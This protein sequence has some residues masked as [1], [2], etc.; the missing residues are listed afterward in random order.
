[1]FVCKVASHLT[2]GE[3]IKNICRR[4]GGFGGTTACGGRSRGLVTASV[5]SG[6]ATPPAAGD[7]IGAW[8][9]PV[10]GHAPWPNRVDEK[11]PCHINGL[12]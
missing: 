5:E 9:R 4:K 6:I 1:M 12:P 3:Y 11:Q 8:P 10:C 2:I 7:K